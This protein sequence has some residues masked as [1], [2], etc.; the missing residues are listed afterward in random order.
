MKGGIASS[1]VAL[2]VV[3]AAL[4][5]WTNYH[6]EKAQ[7]AHDLAEVEFK[8]E[9]YESAQEHFNESF[10]AY[11]SIYNKDGQATAL[12]H[13]SKCQ[14]SQGDFEE[15]VE[16]LGRAVKLDDRESFQAAL[17]KYHR[18]AAVDALILSHEFIEGEN[19]EQAER[20]AD[21]ALKRFQAGEGSEKQLAGAFQ[22][23]AFCAA[24]NH[25]FEKADQ[26]LDQAI[27]IS[28]DTKQTAAT[29]A[30]IEQL[31]Q[32]YQADRLAA[33]KDNR[34]IPDGE[35]D[36]SALSPPPQRRT[37]IRSTGRSSVYKPKKRRS[38]YSYNRRPQVKKTS[39]GTAAA[40]PKKRPAYDDRSRGSIYNRYSPVRSYRQNRTYNGNSSPYRT[41]TKKP[42]YPTARKSYRSPSSVYSRP[43]YSRSSSRVRSR[44]TTFKPVRATRIGR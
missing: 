20:Q 7:E 23:S 33:A 41:R 17:L 37:L 14:M 36:L 5:F 24:L 35:L 34:Y 25:D 10:L 21:L 32:D 31:Y 1:A 6:L 15:A 40:Y 8:Q 19:F 12:Y 39:L 3:V 18:I 16:T 38:R 13:L 26:Q 11:R 28:G 27:K 42:I 22:K 2:I 9:E 30:E 29:T 4:S 44:P 43:T